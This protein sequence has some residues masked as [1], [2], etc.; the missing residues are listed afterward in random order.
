MNIYLL[1]N[2][3]WKFFENLNKDSEEL[4]SRNITIDETSSVS[5]GCRIGNNVTILNN[6]TLDNS[7]LDNSRVYNSTVD[8][9]TLD[10]ST[11]DN[12]RVD[13]NSR[14]YN[15]RVDNNSRVNNSRVDN[16]RVYSSTVDNN[17]TVY[18]SRVDN[19]TVYNSRVDNYSAVDNST[20]DNS[21]I[22]DATLDNFTPISIIGSKGI[23]SR[24]NTYPDGRIQIGCL[25][26]SAEEWLETYEQVGKQHNFSEAE[27]EEYGD[28][29]DLL[30]KRMKCQ[31]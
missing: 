7:T 14:V 22:Q 5:D 4:K 19:S 26:K 11:L 21:T 30:I 24:L 1:E 13:N 8:N 15:S 9:S 16:S 17:S 28:Y 12:S 20:V 27:I 29:I 10:N 23:V 2:N 3:I 6:S 18:N 25:K 31:K